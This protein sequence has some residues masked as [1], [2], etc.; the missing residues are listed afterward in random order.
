MPR[1][2]RV[3]CSQ[4]GIERRRRGRGFEYRHA[5]GSR[6]TDAETLARIDS[7]AIPPAWKAVWICTCDNGHLQAVGTDAAGRR[8]YLY[9]DQWRRHRDREKYDRMLEFAC[10][11]PALRD[12]T[13]EHFQLDDMPREKVLACAVR[14]LDRGFFR[15]GTE[16][17][18]D[19]NGTFG[20]ATLL[21]DHV[22]VEHD[23]LVFDYPAKHGIRRVQ[24]LSDPDVVEVVTALKRR[25]GGLPQLLAWRDGRTW[26]D[27]TSDD[28]NDYIHRHGGEQFSAKDFRTWHATVLSA[29]ALAIADSETAASARDGKLLSASSR[30]RTITRVVK[31]VSTYLGNTPTVCRSSYI[32]PR[33]FDRYES[34][35]TIAG[36][37][38]KLKG[39][40]D[41][42]HPA[43]QRALE[44][45]VL[46]LL[47]GRDARMITRAAS[48]VLATVPA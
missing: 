24:C 23:V 34:G 9:H 20:I 31:E 27:I 36:A 42:E 11:L 8:Q 45:A 35:S 21:K 2:R 40:E 16:Q 6:V 47:E 18:A 12:T 14:M 19:E 33:V 5:D 4:P 25:R 1:L 39:F 44:S 38:E 48:Q 3:D 26:V 41:F 29:L 32:D 30:K 7:L 10:V 37:V 28:I 17:Y 22:T 13:H 46:G 43:T 15:V